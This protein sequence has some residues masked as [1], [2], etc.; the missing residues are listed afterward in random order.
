MPLKQ[1]NGAATDAPT[2]VLRRRE[3]QLIMALKE[4]EKDFM[5]NGLG[6]KRYGMREMSEAGILLGK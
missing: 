1:R 3:K 6:Q 2:A 5:G 4:K